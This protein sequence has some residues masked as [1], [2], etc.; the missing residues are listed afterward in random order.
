MWHVLGKHEMGTIFWLENHKG[1]DYL[2]VV[3]IRGGI[4]KMY[5]GEFHKR[6]G[7]Y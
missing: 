5:L 6:W 7:I 4:I 3:I 2:G 1:L